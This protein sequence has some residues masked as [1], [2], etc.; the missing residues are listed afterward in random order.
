MPEVWV[1]SDG[2]LVAYR[3]RSQGGYTAPKRS[4][5]LPDID[6]VELARY[7]QISNQLV[8]AKSYRASLRKH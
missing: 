5:L 7:A 3:R 6:L 2:A 4:R 1:W 8:A